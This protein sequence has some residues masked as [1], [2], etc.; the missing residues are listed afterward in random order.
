MFADDSLEDYEDEEVE[1][2]N[3]DHSADSDEESIEDWNADFD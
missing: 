1:E 3:D 2:G